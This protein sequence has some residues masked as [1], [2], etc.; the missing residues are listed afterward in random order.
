MS[1]ARE[2]HISNLNPVGTQR[3]KILEMF[4]SSGRLEQ[5]KIDRCNK[6]KYQHRKIKSSKYVTPR[7][8]ANFEPFPFRESRV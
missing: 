2:R 6:K 1:V 5:R 3:Y 7:K 8:E 4:C